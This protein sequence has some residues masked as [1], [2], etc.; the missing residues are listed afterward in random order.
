MRNEPPPW[1]LLVFAVVMTGVS[2]VWLI[3]LGVP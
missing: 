1:G 3:A 2:A